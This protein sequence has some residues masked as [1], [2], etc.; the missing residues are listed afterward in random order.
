M[1]PKFYQFEKMEFEQL[2]EKIARKYV[3]GTNAMLVYFMLKKGAI[4]PKHHHASEQI[5]YIVAGKVKV[6]SQ[7]K[8]YIVSKGEVLIIPPNTPHF[9]EA[10]E[11][12]IDVDVF[13]P[14]RQ[15]WLNGTDDYLKG[16]K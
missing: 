2:S 9:F 11:D 16:V 10:L 15:D 1:E 8:E 4:I 3:Y 7:D 14:I 12:T 6:I 5:T 13:S